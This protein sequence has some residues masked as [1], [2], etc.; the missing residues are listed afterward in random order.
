VG[1]DWLEIAGDAQPGSRAKRGS[2]RDIFR[3]L[4]EFAS[5]FLS[6][7][8]LRFFC[9]AMNSAVGYLL[10]RKGTS[11]TDQQDVPKKLTARVIE[12]L[13]DPSNIKKSIMTLGLM[14]VAALLAGVFLGGGRFLI[15]LKDSEISRGLITF[16]VALTTVLLAI[17]LALYAITAEDKESVKERFSLGKEV[18]TTLVGILGTVLGFYFGSADKSLPNQLAIAELKFHGQ[19]LMTHI[20]GGTPPYRYSITAPNQQFSKIEARLSKD[21]WVVEVLD[22]QPPPGTPILVNVSDAKD[23]PIS[24]ESLFITGQLTEKPSQ[25]AA[26][27]VLPSLPASPATIKQ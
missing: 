21:G 14:A 27:S 17:I 20:S 15:L 1:G 12:Q 5:R 23:K 11:M 9:R 10:P 3:R 19:Q 8:V 24:V 6:L 22:K 7:P 4:K 26:S 25:G 13:T 2:G 16:L 18:L